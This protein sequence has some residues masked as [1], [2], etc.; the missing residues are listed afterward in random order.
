MVEIECS[1]H[2]L[3]SGGWDEG[4]KIKPAKNL[5][6]LNS[7][8]LKQKHKQRKAQE[9]PSPI[10]VIGRAWEPLSSTKEFSCLCCGCRFSGCHG[11]VKAEY[12]EK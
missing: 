4:V 8:W 3:V 10:L 11:K 1:V 5:Q 9:C 7:F 6:G 12:L 2:G